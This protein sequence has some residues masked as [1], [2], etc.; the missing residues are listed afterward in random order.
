MTKKYNGAGARGTGGPKGKWLKT[1]MDDYI[2]Q[3]HPELRMTK[4]M[5]IF[6]SM[7]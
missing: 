2:K 1:V 5:R 6:D 3:N 4:I 7:D